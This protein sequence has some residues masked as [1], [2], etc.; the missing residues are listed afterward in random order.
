M[1]ILLLSSCNNPMR[2]L[3]SP[4]YSRRRQRLQNRGWGRW[5][6][7]QD[8]TESSAR[9]SRC[10]VSRSR[11]V[12]SEPQYWMFTL[13]LYES[14]LYVN[15]PVKVRDIMSLKLVGSSV[16]LWVTGELGL[17]S[18]LQ[19]ESQGFQFMQTL[20]TTCLTKFTG[21]WPSTCNASMFMDNGR[22]PTWISTQSRD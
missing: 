21:G 16:L 10:A 3:L 18:A 13:C 14:S 19:P 1:Y 2:K 4:L 6:P 7:A 9:K 20:A 12:L 8:Y 17:F 11:L 22:V 5:W 15:E